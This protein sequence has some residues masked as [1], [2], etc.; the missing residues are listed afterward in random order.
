MRCARARSNACYRDGLAFA[1]PR[2]GF[3]PRPATP[4]RTFGPAGLTATRLPSSSEWRYALEAL[5][6]TLRLVTALVLISSAASAFVW[7]T[8]IERAA[9]NLRSSDVAV[10]RRAAKE[11]GTFPRATVARLGIPA[12]SDPDADVR[13]VTLEAL[14][15]RRVTGLGERVTP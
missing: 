6:R 13:V 4:N 14:L 9:E 5:R 7:P 8:A 10:R 3:R 11:L 12:L 1:V 2:Q 15:A